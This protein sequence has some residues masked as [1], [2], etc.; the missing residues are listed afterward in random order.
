MITSARLASRMLRT[1]AAPAPAP[2]ARLEVYRGCAAGWQPIG[3]ARPKPSADRLAALVAR[4]RPEAHYRIT[5]W[6]A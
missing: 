3:Q 6:A 1:L 5:P 4:I 2:L